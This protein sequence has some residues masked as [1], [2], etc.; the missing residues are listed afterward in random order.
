MHRFRSWRISTKLQKEK[1]D[2][3]T[4]R[5]ET[6]QQKLKEKEQLD[7]IKAIYEKEQCCFCFEKGKEN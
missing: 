1:A 6:A 7:Q 3:A 5:A 4:K 2:R